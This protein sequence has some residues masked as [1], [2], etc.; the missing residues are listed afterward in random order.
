M[1]MTTV[2]LRIKNPKDES[3]FIEEEFLVDS[4][5]AFTVVPKSLLEKIGIKGQREQK[6]TLADG[7]IIKR[8]I[9]EAIFEMNGNRAPGP[10][11]IG[12]KNDSL[13]LGTLTLEAMGLVLDPFE[14]KLYKAKLM[15]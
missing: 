3:K 6:F 1:G 9:G 15:L 11:V 7:R 10:V 12:K 13:L 5:A 2:I 14:R 8:K 4:G